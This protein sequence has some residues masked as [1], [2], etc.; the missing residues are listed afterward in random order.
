MAVPHLDTV[1]IV[2]DPRRCGGDPTLAGTRIAVHDVVSYA[3]LCG[4]DLERVRA[5]ALPDLSLAQL[6]AAMEWYSHNQEEI[7]TILNER[8][9]DYARGSSAADSLR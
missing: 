9:E 2:R 8:R 1:V 3:R 4:G 7:D 6:R 5:E